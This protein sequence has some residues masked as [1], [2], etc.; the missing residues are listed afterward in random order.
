MS[1]KLK[2]LGRQTEIYNVIHLKWRYLSISSRSVCS[3]WIWSAS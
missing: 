2:Y 1:E 3:R